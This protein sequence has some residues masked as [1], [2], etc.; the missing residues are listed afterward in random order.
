MGT[1]IFISIILG[2]FVVVLTLF[3]LLDARRLRKL[4]AERQG[5][6]ICRFARSLDYRR[7]DTKV[8]RGVYEGVQEY[9]APVCPAFPVRASDDI[10]KD[11]R[12]DRDDY[13]DMIMT[14]ADRCGRNIDGWERNPY[15]YR[16]STISGLIEFLCA[17]PKAQGI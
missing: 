8:I 17:Q 9:F 10:D 4:A 11:Y 15:Y 12:I 6:S 5:D 7:L 16:I 13:M 1:L 14:I 2:T 3:G